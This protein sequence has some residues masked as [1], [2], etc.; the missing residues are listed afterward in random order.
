MIRRPPRSTL[1]PYTTLFRSQLAGARG[2][3]L[4][5]LPGDGHGH[6]RV[7]A[8][9]RLRAR[10]GR[11]A[12][13][14]PAP[15]DAP[16]SAR[17]AVRALAVLAAL[18]LAGVAGARAQ[19]PGVLLRLARAQLEDA[20]PDSAATLLARALDP[21]QNAGA[22]EQA[23]AWTLL[24][25][26]ELMRGRSVSA[27][28]A[29]RH[30]L[31]RDPSLSVDS[32]T[33]L[34]SDMRRVFAAEREA[35]RLESDDGPPGVTVRLVTDTVIAPNAGQWPIEVQP[36]RPARVIASLARAT[37][38]AD[39]LWSDTESVNLAGVIGW[40]LRVRGAPVAP[41]RHVL[42]VMATDTLGRGS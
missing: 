24:G 23:R 40:D 27:R 31:E 15:P 30:A 26:A 22:A 9:H 18:L 3:R 10:R 12:Q 13:P 4:H 28:L 35:F 17:S 34:Q 8:R 32:L 38:R 42:R 36:R 6:R 16:M 33:Y 2:P 20:K 21:R 25:A 37:A 11:H 39:I 5:P 1:F 41:G 7:A 19:N 29:F 14:A